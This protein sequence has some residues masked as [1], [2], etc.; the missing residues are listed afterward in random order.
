MT[1]P[2][3]DMGSEG[4]DLLAAEYVL[5]V[6]SLA[7]R[8]AF[9]ARLK[10]DRVLAERTR[11]WENRLAD[12]NDDYAPVPAPDVLHRIEKRLFLLPQRPPRRFALWGGLLGGLVAAGLLVA[13][14]LTQF[15]LPTGFE[16]SLT[17]TL[18][19][20]GQPLVFAAS[21][22]R[23]KATLRIERTGGTVAEVGKD[24]E[25][26]L[27]DATGV[28]VSLGVL[29][30]TLVETPLAELLPGIVLA[31]SLEPAGGSATGLPTGPV[32][33]SGPVTEI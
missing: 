15:P 29:G 13:V 7:D 18:T 19:A 16:P 14:V 9:G 2:T 20:E 22:D 5:G 17:A 27:I 12:L 6:L 24:Y 30:D 25:L 33:V 23:E 1:Q 31:V 32:L 21:Y 3:E 28:P 4:D 10:S 8:L 26:W 11:V